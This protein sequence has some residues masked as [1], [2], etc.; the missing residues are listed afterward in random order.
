MLLLNQDK[1]LN[2]SND[3][4][5]WLVRAGNNAEFY[6]DF[7]YNNFIAVGNN[8]ISLSDLK[9]INSYYRVNEDILENQ[10]KEIFFKNFLSNYNSNE[11]NKNKDRLTRQN[12]LASLKRSSSIAASKV[13]NFVEKMVV[14]DFVILPDQGSSKFLL[15][16]ILSDAFDEEINHVNQETIFDEMSDPG[17]TISNFQKKRRVFWIKEFM[18][19]DLPDKL[20]WIRQTR[21]SI[22]NLTPYA[23]QINPLISANYIYNGELHCR[24]GVTTN[25][26]VSSKDL[27]EFQ[28]LI[29]ELAEEKSNEI[30]QKT[31]I[32]S[33]GFIL[34][35]TVLDNWE[36]LAL[37][38]ACIFG[39][40]AISKS[41]FSIKITGIVPY[42][43]NRKFKK[44]LQN[45]QLRSVKIKNDREETQLKK[46]QLELKHLELKLSETDVQKIQDLKLTNSEVG[47]EIPVEMQIDNLSDIADLSEIKKA[48]EE[49]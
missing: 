46:E 17:Y 31:N 35:Q 3:S 33:P 49:K 21:Q 1:I 18:Q 8:N 45:E 40:V 15:G 32:Q 30:H 38:T 22:Y 14:G 19:K 10:Y 9:N 43:I 25:K 41:N 24:I 27:F 4:Q 44:S 12:E 26:Q 11:N 7:Q 47:N 5:Y 37:I 48:P 2:I 34:L 13:F 23:E 42:F 28:K 29:V 36:S 20:S 39:D 16:F 6:E